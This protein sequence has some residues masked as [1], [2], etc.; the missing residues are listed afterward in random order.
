MFKVV[1]TYHR[2][3]SASNTTGITSG[4]PELIPVINGVCASQSLVFYACLFV[5]FF[6]LFYCLYFKLQLLITPLVSSD[7]SHRIYRKQK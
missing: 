1:L 4:A 7:I 6:W 5:F 2:I 3:L